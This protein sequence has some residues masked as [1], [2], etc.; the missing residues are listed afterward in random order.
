MNSYFYPY[1]RLR[2][3]KIPNETFRNLCNP[4]E[5]CIIPKNP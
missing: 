4:A 2:T 3:L 5:T 1:E